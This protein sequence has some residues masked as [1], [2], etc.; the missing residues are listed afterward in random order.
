MDWPVKIPEK[1]AGGHGRVSVNCRKV[2]HLLSAY[3]DG[4][5][6]GVEHRQVHEHLARCAECSAEYAGLLRTKRLL[7][8]LRVQEPNPELPANI[9]HQIQAREAHAPLSGLARFRQ[10]SVTLGSSR[11]TTQY[12][13]CGVGLTLVAVFFV[14]RFIDD[15]SS[16]NNVKWY[17]SALSAAPTLQTVPAEPTILAPS[18]PFNS[19][20]P[21]L[22]PSVRDVSTPAF[23]TY[24]PL[25]PDPSPS[26]RPGPFRQ[27]RP[28]G[29][30]QWPQ[31]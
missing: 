18:M 7:S 23:R 14:A 24:T 31:R 16:A 4:E 29:L 13:A 21:A 9:L 19:W 26:S 8:A 3:I 10:W 17:P 12:L 30:P 20:A 5:L 25:L 22:S 15:D 11:M 6:P 1:S 27:R 28:S 2:S